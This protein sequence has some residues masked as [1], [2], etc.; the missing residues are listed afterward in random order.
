MTMKRNSHAFD[1]KISRIREALI[2][3]GP[4]RPGSLTRQY[5]KP[6]EKKLPFWQLNYMRHMKSKSEYIR[7]E[8]VQAIRKELAEYKRFKKLVEAW[9]DIGIEQSRARMLVE[10]EKKVR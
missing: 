1:L 3:I 5:R 10:K 4:M 9:I 7:E 8:H 2:N 6:A